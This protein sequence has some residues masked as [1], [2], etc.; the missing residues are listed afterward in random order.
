LNTARE[1]VAELP[2]H[3]WLEDVHLVLATVIVL[4]AWQFMPFHTLLDQY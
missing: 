3:V 2:R 1:T 4:V